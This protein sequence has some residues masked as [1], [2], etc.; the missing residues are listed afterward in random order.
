MKTFGAIE[1]RAQIIF[2]SGFEKIKCFKKGIYLGGIVLP[3]YCPDRQ[4]GIGTKTIEKVEGNAQ[5]IF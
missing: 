3:G 5:I 4:L 2:K 1:G